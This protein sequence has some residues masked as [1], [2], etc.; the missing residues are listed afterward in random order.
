MKMRFLWAVAL[1]SFSVAAWADGPQATPVD[2]KSIAVSLG[3]G[4]PAP[5]PAASRPAPPPVVPFE[6]LIPFLPAAP[7]G[8]TAEKPSGSVTDVEVFRLSTASRIYEKGDDQNA[9]VTTVTVLDAGGHQGYFDATTGGWKANSQ[10]GDGYD[11]T[12]EIDGLPG[13][14]HYSRT[15]QSGSLSVIVAKRFFVQIDVKNQEPAA[16]R[17]WLKKLDLKK[18]AELK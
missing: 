1:V 7:E 4:T 6:K 18:L 13:F 5:T 14:E 9:A 2:L 3:A 15:A 10:T 8:W 11:K 12:V 17:E 16:L